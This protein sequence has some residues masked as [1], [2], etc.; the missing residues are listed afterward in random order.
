MWVVN[1][2]MPSEEERP[3]DGP[4]RGKSDAAGS[5]NELN[6]FCVVADLA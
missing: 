5:D 2:K 1:G 4:S 6:A 3:G